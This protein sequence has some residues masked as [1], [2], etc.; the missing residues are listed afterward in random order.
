[1]PKTVDN[2]FDRRANHFQF[3]IRNSQFAIK[4]LGI[5]TLALNIDTNCFVFQN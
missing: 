2:D 4:R 3:A 1:M 5:N